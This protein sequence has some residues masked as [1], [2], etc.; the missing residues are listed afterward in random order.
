[1][2]NFY[3]KG[4]KVCKRVEEEARLVLGNMLF[5]TIIPK[6]SA[7]GYAACEEKPI[8]LVNI[9]SSGAK[10]YMALAQEIIDKNSENSRSDR[11]GIYF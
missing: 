8:A 3:E 2:L 5:K 9:S 1:M 7:L 4:T 6:N 10:A 11:S